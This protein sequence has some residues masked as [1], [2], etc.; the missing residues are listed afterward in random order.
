MAIIGRIYQSLPN[1]VK[2][3]S[4]N[5]LDS[6]PLIR[7]YFAENSYLRTKGW[8]RSEQVGA[9]VDRQGDPIP[10][11]TYP[12][13]DFI[14]PRLEQDFR[15][16]EFGSGH[17]SLWYSNLVDEVVAVEDSAEWVSEMR[18]RAPSNLNIVHQPDLT[19]Y[20]AEVLGR[21]EFDIIV[22]D[23]LARQECVKPTLNA[24]SDNGVVI[25]DDFERWHDRDWRSLREHGFRS[26]PFTGPKAQ[27]LTTSCTAV[28]YRDQ[29]CLDL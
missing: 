8:M 10:W 25:L 12:A 4:R 15:V 19:D 3:L 7:W 18:D 20:P 11:Y 9:P 27:R 2:N 5:F 22:I 16:F 29:N 21:G 28:L 23:G 6:H 24:I 17:S 1:N 14:K 26:L 13:I